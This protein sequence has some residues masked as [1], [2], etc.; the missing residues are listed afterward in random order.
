M[1]EMPLRSQRQVTTSPLTEICNGKK[2]Q[3]VF[4]TGLKV[5]SFFILFSLFCIYRNDDHTPELR[6]GMIKLYD[7]EQ[8]LNLS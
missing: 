5:S 7:I 6:V 3:N 2:R 4:F 8:K 1:I